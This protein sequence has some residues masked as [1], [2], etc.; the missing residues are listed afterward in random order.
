METVFG[1]GDGISLQENYAHPDGSLAQVTF[2]F[3]SKSECIAAL[4]TGSGD[5]LFDTLI[6]P[7]CDGDE[8]G[9]PEDGKEDVYYDVGVGIREAF[10][11]YELG[12]CGLVYQKRDGE[13]ALY[14]W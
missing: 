4:V 11:A 2:P 8:C 14:Y 13:P 1:R 10:C 9:E 6:R 7:C 5:A 3:S 12:Y